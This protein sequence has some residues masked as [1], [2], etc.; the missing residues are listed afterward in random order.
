MRRQVDF[1]A[2]LGH[3]FLDPRSSALLQLLHSQETPAVASRRCGMSY[4][5]TCWLP[6]K[7]P[8]RPR[9]GIDRD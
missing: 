6:G 2:P 8:L 3:E 1:P 7:P 5:E 9:S 4:R